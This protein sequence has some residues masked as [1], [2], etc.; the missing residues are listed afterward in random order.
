V[1][2]FNLLSVKRLPLA[3]ILLLSFSSRAQPY[4]F[5][6]YETEN[7]LSNN[8]VLSCVQDKDGFIWFGTAD[9]LDRFDGIHFKSFAIPRKK[10]VNL[11]SDIIMSLAIGNDGSL[12][13][14]AQRGLHKFDKE[15]ERL[16]LFRDSADFVKN[17]E[18]DNL[19]QL[20]FIARNTLFVYNSS[21]KFLRSFNDFIPTSL[22]KSNGAVW[23]ADTEGN[24]RRFNKVK[25]TFEKYNLSNHSP[26]KPIPDISVI[27]S[28]QKGTI[29]IGTSNQQI[30]KFSTSTLTYTDIALRGIG[31]AI[32][33]IYQILPVNDQEIW[34][35]SEKGIL[36]FNT[37]A[38][39]FYRIVKKPLDPYSLSDDAVVML[40]KDR[41]GGIWAG[42]SFGG[43]NY[44]PKLN[45]NFQKYFADY[46]KNSIGGNVIRE[47]RQDRLGNLWLASE[48]AGITEMDPSTGRARRF[49]PDEMPGSISY[50]NV[51]GL[52]PVGDDLW[53]GTHF[54]GLDIMD[55]SSGKVKKHYQAGDRFGD[56]P[57]NF[58]LTFLRTKNGSIYVGTRKGLTKYNPST[59]NFTR[60][61]YIPLEAFIC[62]LLEDRRGN[63]WVATDE[64]LHVFDPVNGKITKE[65]NRFENGMDDKISYMHISSV[66]Q[67][68][69]ANIWVATQG[70]GLWKISEDQKKFK[71]YTVD[72]GLPSNIISKVLEDNNRT[73]WVTTSNGLV[74]LQS[75]NDSVV[76][77]TKE[78]GLLND[79]FTYNSGLKDSLG[80]L[81]FGSTKGIV[82]FN[83]SVFLQRKT[84]PP[85][86]FTGFQVNNK[87][88]AIGN[89][90]VLKKTILNTDLITLTHDQSTFSI[91]FAALN[92]SA[93]ERIQYSYQMQ[94]IDTGWTLLGRN[95]KVYFTDL[96]PGGY[97]FKVRAASI[98]F[99]G[100][101][102]KELRIKIR[103]PLWATLWA[104]LLYAL[105]FVAL[106]WYLL[107]SYLAVQESKKAKQLI[108]AKIEFFTNIAH[109]IK[110][111]LTLIKGPLENLSE[112][113]SEIPAI[114]EDVQTMER[115][116]T[117]LMDLSAQI[118]DFRQTQLEA[119]H[120]NFTFVSIT[121]I[122]K[123]AYDTFKPLAKKRNLD[124]SIDLPPSAINSMADREAL[125][126]IFNNL[127]SNAVKYA[128]SRVRV[129]LLPPVENRVIVEIK[130][131]GLLIIP[132]MKEKI[133]EP[134]VR[135]KESLYQKGTGIGL[136][137]ARSLA[138]LHNGTLIVKQA[139]EMNV[140]ILEIPYTTASRK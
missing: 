23:F 111:P 89:D 138:E 71:R 95:R 123:E 84:T 13:V 99:T 87:D 60:I 128:E 7:G 49:A 37:Q 134:F 6:H 57:S 112:M 33:F 120:M 36:V 47:I 104:Y 127:L 133:F 55:M 136:T 39:T 24:L 140:F 88:V 28:D 26:G 65:E 94:G 121:E 102:E 11:L 16:L 30:K 83:P 50:S 8:K 125:N 22:C 9:G 54:H 101:Q 78:D 86:Y 85:L 18:F 122:I 139:G 64:G 12:W 19:G 5:R 68:S 56:L 20:W 48:D 81:Y 27:V 43:L 72:D 38:E 79:Q 114:E 109:E 117:R 62:A 92:Y 69:Y 137:L 25:G 14:G 70:N 135:L 3:L 118:L 126:K 74:N 103:P 132:E 53:I 90:S 80:T 124:Y 67:D 110:T 21:E 93:P 40:Y 75:L 17:M 35:G 91:D 2:E 4:Y 10:K 115:N 15:N 61:R 46:S 113:T 51:Q 107:R 29:Y 119:Y 44:C 45:Y 108:E 100:I 96:K 1:R 129:H 31:P 42:T 97:V 52:L 116:T 32:G 63:I 105:S 66:F 131:D 106:A 76:I 34:F 98:N 130:N 41:E 82:A 77:Y 59:D 58:V 73:L